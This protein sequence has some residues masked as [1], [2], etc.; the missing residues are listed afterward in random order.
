[1]PVYLQGDCEEGFF[2]GGFCRVVDAWDVGA[3]DDAFPFL[4]AVFVFPEEGAPLS[5]GDDGDG[6]WVKAVFRQVVPV[7]PVNED[8]VD[9]GCPVS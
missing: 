9:G 2:R 8:S 6:G 4:V 3:L 7:P 1:M 5:L